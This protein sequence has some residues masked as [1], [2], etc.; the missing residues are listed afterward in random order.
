MAEKK[1]PQKTPEQV[2]EQKARAAARSAA[3]SRLREAHREEHDAYLVEEMQ[4]RGI[5]WKPKPTPE[6]KAKADLE[7]I[8]SEYP[9]LKDSAPAGDSDG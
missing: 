2:E 7:K 1:T 8:Y 6:E 9:H 3:A 4:K 5:D